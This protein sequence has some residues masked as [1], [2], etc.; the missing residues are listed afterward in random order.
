MYF[1]VAPN[2]V[3]LCSY[4]LRIL[5]SCCKHSKSGQNAFLAVFNLFCYGI[6][7]DGLGAGNVGRPFS[8]T[9]PLTPMPNGLNY[10]GLST[11]HT[12]IAWAYL[13]IANS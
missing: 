9:L 10:S 11:S 6:G 1:T 3:I 8:Y 13:E 2:N 7:F 4:M 12:R 5:L